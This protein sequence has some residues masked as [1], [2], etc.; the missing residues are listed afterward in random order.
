MSMTSYWNSAWHNVNSHRVVVG[1]GPIE[2]KNGLFT[3]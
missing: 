1:G 3:P 2:Q